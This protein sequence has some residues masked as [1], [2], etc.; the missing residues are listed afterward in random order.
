[1]SNKNSKKSL[2]II[3]INLEKKS[4]FL[5]FILLILV[6]ISNITIDDY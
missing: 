6:I 4:H 3:F 1:M 2:F 5:L